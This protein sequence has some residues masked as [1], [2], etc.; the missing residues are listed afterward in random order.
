MEKEWSIKHVLRII[1]RNWWVILVL[2]I[3]TTIAGIVGSGYI[4]ITYSSDTLMLVKSEGLPDSYSQATINSSIQQRIE[5][6]K[7]Q[8]LSRNRLSKIIRKFDLYMKEIEKTS[9]ENAIRQMRQDIKVKVFASVFRITYDGKDEPEKIMKVTDELASL[10]IEENLKYKQQIYAAYQFMERKVREAQQKAQ[11]FEE[12]IAEFKNKNV[13]SLPEHLTTNLGA[14]TS[15]LSL[16]QTMTRNLSQAD[17]EVRLKSKEF[18]L[19]LDD[20]ILKLSQEYN[21]KKGVQ[22]LDQENPS[23]DAIAKEYKA[24]VDALRDM[25]KDLAKLKGE[26]RQ[27]QREYQPIHPFVKAKEADVKD[28]E[29]EVLKFRESITGT[30]TKKEGKGQKETYD[31][32]FSPEE[33]QQKKKM[34]DAAIKIRKSYG[35]YKV[36]RSELL[37][38]EAKLENVPEDKIPAEV[39]EKL[40][41]L[42]RKMEQLEP[43]VF[44][45]ANVILQKD[46]DHLVVISKLL[47]QTQLKYGYIAREIKEAKERLSF[48]EKR[49]QE[50]PAAEQKLAELTREKELAFKAYDFIL[51]STDQAKMLKDLKEERDAGEFIVLDPAYLPTESQFLR[52]LLVWIVSFGVGLVGGVGIGIQRD[53]LKPRV[54]DVDFLK[55]LSQNNLYNSIPYF[56]LPK[57]KM[58]SVALQNIWPALLSEDSGIHKLPGQEKTPLALTSSSETIPTNSA[59]ISTRMP[60]PGMIDVLQNTQEIKKQ[61]RAQAEDVKL[62]RKKDLQRQLRDMEV[63]IKIGEVLVNKRLLVNNQV[64]RLLTILEEDLNLTASCPPIELTTVANLT[65]FFAP[66][67]EI[68]SRYRRLRF[69]IFPRQVDKEPPRKVLFTSAMPGEGKTITSFNV[70]GAIATGIADKVIWIECNLAH[71]LKEV[72]AEEAPKGLANILAEE[73]ELADVLRQTQFERFKVLPAGTTHLNPSELLASKAMTQLVEQIQSTYPDHFLIFDAPS[74]L[75]PIDISSLVALVDSLVMVVRAHSTAPDNLKKALDLIDQTKIGGFILNGVNRNELNDG[76]S[77]EVAG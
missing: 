60:A 7:D 23:D 24:K 27:L 43:D 68:A 76:E 20:V 29:K 16:L 2:T 55:R 21:K 65:T 1:K 6:I 53:I 50:T 36:T 17:D 9:L 75:S 14:R 64:Y 38:V 44:E 18:E 4:P 56:K 25:Y 22:I 77:F 28:K 45:M 34:L 52:N 35:I 59:T 19:G 8:V 69:Q 5:N 42:K 46:Y 67:S 66:T 62:T 51:K 71:P 10:F 49:I 58:K 57:W 31:Y 48:Y 41:E 37:T 63:P 3:F 73:V 39:Q 15:F 70:A 26:L 72:F 61:Q 47:Y 11:K 54:E 33:R 40:A 74:I 32:A 13:G 12:A 30:P